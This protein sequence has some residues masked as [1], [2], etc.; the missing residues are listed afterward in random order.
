MG[1]VRIWSNGEKPPE[2]KTY[3]GKYTACPQ[4][5][6]ARSSQYGG[7]STAG[8][9]RRVRDVQGA[10]GYQADA[11]PVERKTY[12]LPE[13]P[14]FGLSKEEYDNHMA[15]RAE[16]AAAK[17]K[18]EQDRRE[19]EAKAT[20]Q[21]ANDEVRERQRQWRA[22]NEREELE[23]QKAEQ[24]R[25]IEQSFTNSAIVSALEA[26][27]ATVAETERVGKLIRQNF[28]A[29]GLTIP[30]LWEQTLEKIRT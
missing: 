9:F 6:A 27:Q 10:A 22:Q 8:G 28:G 24:A 25:K 21:K 13:Y 18:R 26:A 7:G 20:R 17:A 14:N 29:A 4:E 3:P 30:S 16:R 12:Y 5:T 23:K 15:K 1:R 19:A 11:Q 2:P